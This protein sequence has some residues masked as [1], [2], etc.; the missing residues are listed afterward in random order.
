MGQESF[1]LPLP[2]PMKL[3]RLKEQGKR[4]H[5]GIKKLKFIRAQSGYTGLHV[6]TCTREDVL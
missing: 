2:A 3:E 5:S 1:P 6:G 4:S